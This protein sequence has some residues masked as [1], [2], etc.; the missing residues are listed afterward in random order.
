VFPPNG[1]R[2]AVVRSVVVGVDDCASHRLVG[3]RLHVWS[4]GKGAWKRDLRLIDT[5]CERAYGIPK[6][7][8]RLRPVGTSNVIAGM[9]A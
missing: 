8:R 5:C 2:T 6:Y 3:G 1:T 9:S 4:S 7:P